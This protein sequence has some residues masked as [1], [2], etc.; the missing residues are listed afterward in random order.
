MLSVKTIVPL[1]FRL[2]SAIEALVGGIRCVPLRRACAEMA[3]PDDRDFGWQG[4][5][6]GLSGGPMSDGDDE[7]GWAEAVS[8]LNADLSE[9]P[10]GENSGGEVPGLPGGEPLADAQAFVPFQAGVV[11]AGGEDFVVLA[12]APVLEFADKLALYA[13]ACTPELLEQPS[14]RVARHFVGNFA[15]ILNTTQL[16]TILDVERKSLR[17]ARAQTAALTFLYEKLAWRHVEK[18][19][20]SR[21]RES[22]ELLSYVEFIT[23]DGVDLSLQTREVIS[24]DHGIVPVAPGGNPAAHGPDGHEGR[25]I[26]EQVTG[27]TKL[28]NS[29][30]MVAMTLRINGRLVMFTSPHLTTLGVVDR[31]TAECLLAAVK[32]VGHGSEHREVFQRKTRL[33]VTDGAKYNLK[34][35]RELMRGRD[36]GWGQLHFVCMA[37]ALAGAHKRVFSFLDADVSGMIACSL[38]LNQGGQISQF[39]A[40]LR[41]VLCD[42]LVIRVEGLDASAIGYKND[43]MTLFYGDDPKYNP[44]RLCLSRLANGDWRN[45]SHFE[46]IPQG[47]ETKEQILHLLMSEFLP[48]LVTHAPRTFPRTRWTGFEEA[49][50][51]LGVLCCVHDLLAHAYREYV[52]AIA[53][54]ERPEQEAGR[55]DPD[56]ADEA[57]PTGQTSST[58]W[59]RANKARRKETLEWVASGPAAHF[60]ILRAVLGP[61]HR[62]LLSVVKAASSVFDTRQAHKVLQ[63]VA[64]GSSLD[65]LMRC[66]EWPLLMAAT[67]KESTR[68]MGEL[69]ALQDTQRWQHFP[70]ARCTWQTQHLVFKMVSRQGCSIQEAVIIPCSQFPFRLFAVL[71]D[72]SALADVRQSCLSSRD[73][74]TQSFLEK[75]DSPELPFEGKLELV[76][77]VLVARMSTVRLESLN[78]TIRRRLIASSTQV[79]K[80]SVATVSAEFMLGKARRREF[81]LK[82][83]PGSKR[84]DNRVRR[85]ESAAASEG[86]P[87]P[88]RGGGGA[89]RAFV[90]EKSR[91]QQKPDF[92]A[93]GVEYNKLTKAAMKRYIDAGREATAIHKRGG[94]CLT[95]PREVVFLSLPLCSTRRWCSCKRQLCGGCTL[96]LRNGRR[97][98]HWCLVS[99]HAIGCHNTTRQLLD[100]ETQC[101]HGA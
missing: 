11:A 57:N 71:V 93:L 53:R 26:V 28:L 50:S 15:H 9:Q 86:Q 17:A 49:L 46:Y 33:T 73:T 29:E 27:L 61:M 89:W 87:R 84:H 75:H 32:L 36:S 70:E 40:A 94:S 74:W 82:F 98:S 77:C 56:L 35:E 16:S 45:K 52:C 65:D 3:A 78:A 66:R 31:N 79:S 85:T 23:Y 14:A 55:A 88:R 100:R 101:K 95:R 21:P 59:A 41:R 25:A 48:A 72:P 96:G 37:H 99:T 30:S 39:R 44:Q 67:A 43:V 91:G 54:T 2:N 12:G 42:R 62:F 68:C 38:S 5:L 60:I 81:E 18:C 22:V 83:R 8:C 13:Q 1:P 19:L 63:K 64:D 20:A 4:A 51:D 80:P 10:H 58:D 92:A 69:A 34:C 90:S 47:A 7:F 24:L 6:D 76:L 97:S